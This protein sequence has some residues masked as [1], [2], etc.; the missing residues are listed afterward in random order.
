M[1]ESAEEQ[2]VLATKVSQHP[3]L[4]VARGDKEGHVLDSIRTLGN[5]TRPPCSWSAL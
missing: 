3:E 5:V 4:V 2:S 1:S